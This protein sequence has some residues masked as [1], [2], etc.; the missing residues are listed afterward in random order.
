MDIDTTGFQ[1]GMPTQVEMLEQQSYLL[2]AENDELRAKL[3]QAQAN[4]TKL[5]DI[6]QGLNKQVAAESLRANGSNVRLVQIGNRLRCIHGID[7]TNWF[8]D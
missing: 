5:V 4:I 8:T 3:A 1:Y 2:M 7:I 6:N